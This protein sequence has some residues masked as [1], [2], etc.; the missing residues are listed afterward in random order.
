MA[1]VHVNG[2][3]IAYQ[4]MGDG[5]D[6]VMVHGL[7]ASRAFWFLQ[8]AMPLSKAF[9][10]TVFD[11]RGHGYS[12]RPATG[13]DAS[14]IAEDLHGLLHHL[15]IERCILVG[16]SFGGGVAMEFAGR[17]PQ[18][19]SHLALLDTKLNSLQ[20]EMRMSDSPYVS[21]FE[22]EVANKTGHDWD[23]ETQVGLR[24]LEVLARWKLAGGGSETRDAFT[25]FGEGR[26][27]AR[28]AKQL[29]DVLDNTTAREDF[30]KV[31][32]DA[33]TIAALPMPVLLVYGEY[34]RCLP[35]YRALQKL[36]PQ[37]ECE[38]IPQG[39]HFFPQSHGRATLMRI[40]R[41]LGLASSAA[42]SAS[43][44]AA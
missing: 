32:V 42:A 2:V 30:V 43:S 40:E 4:Q 33:N 17:Y 41:F 20:P 11:L 23:Q 3:D 1:E 10:V 19:V 44:D 26:G 36:L 35:T 29:I 28:T 31:G 38:M 8:Y 7:A 22:A 5:P 12:S 34:S 13:Y 15:G 9:R 25:P 14:T 21:P 27:A 18:H 39:G 16:H 37:A 6:L 24:F